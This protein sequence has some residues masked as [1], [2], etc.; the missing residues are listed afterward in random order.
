MVSIHFCPSVHCTVEIKEPYKEVD[1]DVATTSLFFRNLQM[2]NLQLKL[3]IIFITMFYIIKCHVRVD[4]GSQ[5]GLVQF[6]GFCTHTKK[7]M[8]WKKSE[9]WVKGEW[10]WVTAKIVEE[11]VTNVLLLYLYRS[12]FYPLFVDITVTLGRWWAF[13]TRQ[14]PC[15]SILVWGK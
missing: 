11:R 9:P 8:V 15:D 13:S 10:V 3:C 14:S 6:K 12:H 5:N 7:K 4:P 2:L 1:G